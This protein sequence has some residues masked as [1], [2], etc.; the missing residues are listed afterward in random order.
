MYKTDIRQ[1]SHISICCIAIASLNTIH[2]CRNYFFLRNSF[3]YFSIMWWQL[4]WCGPAVERVRQARSTSLNKSRRSIQKSV[5]YVRFTKYN[6]LDGNSAESTFVRRVLSWYW[7]LE[8]S[9]LLTTIRSQAGQH[10]R[11]TDLSPYKAMVVGC[12]LTWNCWTA[13][14][15]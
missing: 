9:L 2:C 7:H 8:S 4:L 3:K 6:L 11:L 10:E 1:S 14:A 5:L 12:P 13:E 15:G